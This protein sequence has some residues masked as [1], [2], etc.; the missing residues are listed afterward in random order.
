[1]F[2][3]DA[4]NE[5]KSRIMRDLIDDKLFH[6]KVSKIVDYFLTIL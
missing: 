3:G 5:M 4:I 6:M 2:V 1:M